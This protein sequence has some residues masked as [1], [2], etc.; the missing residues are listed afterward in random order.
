MQGFDMSLQV[1]SSFGSV[2]AK[3]ASI[4]N[5]FAALPIPMTVKT[6]H[7]IEDLSAIEARSRS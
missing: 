2:I 4:T 1:I 3:G 6:F 7:R 5:F